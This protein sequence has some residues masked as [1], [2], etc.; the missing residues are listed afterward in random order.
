MSK[1]SFWFVLLTAVSVAA[2][3]QAADVP[4]VSV[5]IST[6][7]QTVKIKASGEVENIG[8]N[9]A[10]YAITASVDPSSLENREIKPVDPTWSCV[11]ESTTFIPPLGVVLPPPNPGNPN[12]SIT[13]GAGNS[14]NSW[15][16][17]VSS[18]NAGQW[19]LKFK[20]SVT[21]DIWDNI[22]NK[23][24]TDASGKVLTFGPYTAATECTFKATTGQFKI[25]MISSDDFPGHATYDFGLG[26]SG[27]V[28]AWSFDNSKQYTIDSSNA[29]PEGVM[30]MTSTTTFQAS[31]T[32]FVATV[33]VKAKDGTTD[34]GE[35][36]VVATVVKPSS[37]YLVEDPNV[38]GYDHKK[39]TYGLV[40]TGFYVIAP[41]NVSFKNLLIKEWGDKKDGDK[42]GYA[43]Y[44]GDPDPAKNYFAKGRLIGS[45]HP[46]TEDDLTTISC[47]LTYEKTKDRIGGPL[48]N[49]SGHDITGLPSR[50]GLPVSEPKTGEA[51]VFLPIRYQVKIEDKIVV[52]SEAIAN[53]TTSI[54]AVQKQGSKY[55]ITVRKTDLT[56]KSVSSDAPTSTWIYV[57]PP[58]LPFIP[59][60]LPSL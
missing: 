53:G 54:V 30:K 33:K 11:I 20:V 7:E 49:I 60:V 18:P 24:K 25:K 22:A 46:P 8:N 38:T 55:M 56:S 2:F 44:R 34:L 17:K 16:A 23:K 51:T 19:N 1:I 15:S 10:K 5:M 57:I 50:V 26:E 27:T 58:V 32:D 3:C 41:F 29:Q 13:T 28:E 43:E 40:L 39:D 9:T 4:I 59:P 48:L 14:T 6:D 42:P 36:N 47:K 52:G 45:L 35:E 37:I 12:V 21:Y 31:S